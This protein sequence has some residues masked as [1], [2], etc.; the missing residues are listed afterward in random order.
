MQPS[1]AAIK[2]ACGKTIKGF[3]VKARLSQEEVAHDAGLNRSHMFRVESASSNPTVVTVIQLC[4]VMKV[5]PARFM[6]EIERNLT[7][8][9]NN[10]NKP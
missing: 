2:R 6:R 9:A 8:S 10:A 7:V 5:K 4:A 3:R 1:V